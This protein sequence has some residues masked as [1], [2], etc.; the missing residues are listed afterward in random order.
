MDI[1]EEARNSLGKYCMEECKAFC[2]R[3]GFLPLKESEVDI[4]T[5]GKREELLSK[6][7][8]KKNG[9]KYSL[10]MRKG[11]SAIKDNKCQVYDKRPKICRDFPL[12][13]EGKIIMASP[14]CPAV[15]EGKLYPYIKRLL[16]E[17]FKLSESDSF[18]ELELYNFE[19]K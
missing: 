11:C 2:C 14:G 12:F 18:G 13:I 3:K 10:D 17:G 5:L 16:M 7:V 8:L 1:A 19:Y 15:R 4:I 9:D 6:G